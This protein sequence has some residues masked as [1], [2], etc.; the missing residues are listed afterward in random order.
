MCFVAVERENERETVST[1]ETETPETCEKPF[2]LSDA[3]L[4]EIVKS[5][6]G[7]YQNMK[8]Y[9]EQKVE[10]IYDFAQEKAIYLIQ[11]IRDDEMIAY[12]SPAQKEACGFCSIEGEVAKSIWEDGGL[13]A[14]RR[15]IST[16]RK[17]ILSAIR[18]TMKK[19]K[20]MLVSYLF[21]CDVRSDN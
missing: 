18:E 16:K 11:F 20:L 19:S 8:S 3:Q 10:D 4:Q 17:T 5:H 2:G 12:G 7:G 1:R 13:E 21:V 6:M 14:F 9:R 15:G